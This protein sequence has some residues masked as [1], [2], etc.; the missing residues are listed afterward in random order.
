[1]SIGEWTTIN[2]ELLQGEAMS[3]DNVTRIRINKQSIGIIGLTRVMQEMG[4]EYA[5]RPDN[6][7]QT[8]LIKRISEKNYIP[9]PAKEDYGKALLREFNKFLGRPYEEDA[10]EEL[11]IKVLGPGCARCDSLEREIMEVLAEMDMSADLEHVRDVKEI[12]RYGVMGTPALIINGKVKCIGSVPPR[13]KIVQWLK[14][15]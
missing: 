5:D 8:E 14:E 7:V 1:M 4:K 10:S 15:L 11:E 12:G 3:Q 2:G 13:E 9:A 6:E